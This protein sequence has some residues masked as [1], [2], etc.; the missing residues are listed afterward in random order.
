MS[1]NVEDTV[2]ELWSTR[3]HRP[4]SDRKVAGV[5]AAIGH[6]YA[7]D[8]VLVRVAFVVVTLFGG[9]GILLYLLGWLLLPDEGDEASAAESLLGR[10][11][12]SVSSGLTVVLGLALIPATGIVFDDASGVIGLALAAA[13]IFLLHRSRAALGPAHA[14]AGSGTTEPTGTEPGPAAPPES[15]TPPES[16]GEQR[17]PPA[18]DPLSAA[19]FAWDLPEPAPVPP[20]APVPPRA[21]RSKVTPI[22]LGV[23]LLMGGTAAA[24]WPVLS[25][26]YILAVVLGVI[27]LGLVIGSGVRG[28]R[29][30]IPIA[31]PLALLVWVLHAVPISDFRVGEGVWAPATPAQVQ[32]RYEVTMGTGRLDLTRLQIPD[33]QTVRTAIGVGLGEVQVTLPRTIDTQL[34]CRV[35]VGSADCLGGTSSGI[36][37]QVDKRDLGADGPGGGTLILD[38]RSGV[39]NVH[40]IRAR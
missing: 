35:P 27:G 22:T 28:G 40:V 38:V 12:S 11:H 5:A 25:L 33:G 2:R 23:A 32:P 15:A 17:T 26:T 36:P 34:V 16:A 8:P 7:V 20:Q 14:G 21:P 18:W 1:G 6:R 13:G 29:G 31:V 19:P 37:A 3:P 10:G 4:E 30:L 9:A 24:S 39:G